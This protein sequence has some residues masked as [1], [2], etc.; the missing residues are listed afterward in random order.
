MNL[1]QLSTNSKLLII[2]FICCFTWSCSE[3]NNFNNQ[4][5]IADSNSATLKVETDSLVI[6]NKMIPYDFDTSEW[7]EIILLDNSISLDIRYA[8]TNN[9]VKEKMYECARCFLRPIVA[10]KVLNIQTN[11]SDLGLG[12]KLFDCY[13]PHSIQFALWDK[14][15]DT[16]YVTPPKKGSMHNRGLAIDLTIIDSLGNELDMGTAYDYFGEQAYHTYIHPDSTIMSNRKLLKDIM[17][18]HGFRSIRTE[19]WHYSYTM[20]SDLISDWQWPCKTSQIN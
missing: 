2:T 18:T 4:E 19:W 16:R 17:E 5:V 7:T 15:P 20:D 6:K 12:I 3:N 9:F 1:F 10:K 8:D 13:R 11:L 14:M